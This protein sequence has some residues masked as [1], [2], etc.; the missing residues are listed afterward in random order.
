ML[1]YINYP[2]IMY[3]TLSKSGDNDLQISTNNFDT[4]YYIAMHKIVRL[5]CNELLFV[6]YSV[7]T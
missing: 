3:S 5:T 1:W 7:Y 4:I 2:K 6:V